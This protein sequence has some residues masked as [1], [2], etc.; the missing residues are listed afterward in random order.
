MALF[1][2]RMLGPR[3]EYIG[4]LSRQSPLGGGGS[5]ALDSSAW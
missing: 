2:V 3:L 5:A 4:M 1:E